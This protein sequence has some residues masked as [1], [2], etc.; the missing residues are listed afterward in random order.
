MGR[1]SLTGFDDIDDP[2]AGLRDRAVPVIED[3]YRAVGVRVRVG[4]F[5][6]TLQVAYVQKESPHQPV[7]QD[8]AAA[9]LPAHATALGKALL[10]FSPPPVVQKVLA[11]R[12][13][14]FA[15][16]TATS[17]EQVRRDAR[18]RR[19]SA[20]RSAIGNWSATPVQW[21]HPSSVGTAKSWRRS[22]CVRGTWQRTLRFWRAPLVV[23]AGSLSRELGRRPEFRPVHTW[24]HMINGPGLYSSG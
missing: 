2:V 6:E 15:P 21:Q 1:T 23:A 16:S 8:C 14:R 11:R 17:P 22:S 18:E 12:L 13:R 10:A 5:D 4:A 20:S 7:S 19:P 24:H 9:R 3:L